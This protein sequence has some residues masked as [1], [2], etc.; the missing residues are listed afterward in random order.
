MIELL[1]NPKVAVAIVMAAV[2]ALVLYE[3]QLTKRDGVVKTP[4][5]PEHPNCR[6]AAPEIYYGTANGWMDSGPDGT[7]NLD[8][9]PIKKVDQI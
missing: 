3:I 1:W 7:I 2:I 5:V 9:M 6:C 8:A 4:D